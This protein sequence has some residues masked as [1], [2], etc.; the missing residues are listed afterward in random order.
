MGYFHKSMITYN[1]EKHDKLFPREKYFFLGILGLG[2][3]VLDIVV[4]LQE[5]IS[6]QII[7]VGL[8]IAQ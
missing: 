1:Y 3:F 5:V 7:I 8:Q 2:S 4:F 6:S